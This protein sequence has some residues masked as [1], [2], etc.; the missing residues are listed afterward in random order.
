MK[1]IKIGYAYLFFFL[2]N[3]LNKK[4]NILIQW[5]AVFIIL[6]LELL[7]VMSSY[8]QFENAAKVV[9]LPEDFNTLNLLYIIIPLVAIKLWFFERNENWKRYLEEF[10]AWPAEKQKRWNWVM[11]CIVIFVFANLIFS[12]Y[13]MSQIDWKQYR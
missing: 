13:W 3:T 12:F 4:G 10:S 5:K 9:L 8:F 6:I 11:R 1:T 2:Y 7:L